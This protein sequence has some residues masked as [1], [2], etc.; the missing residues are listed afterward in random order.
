[1]P[2]KRKRAG[3]D[4]ETVELELTDPHGNRYKGRLTG[5]VIDGDDYRTIYLTEDERVV[6][7]DADKATYWVVEDPER[8]LDGWP[9]AL[10]ALGITPVVDI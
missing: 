9:A 4:A 6:V 3:A 10:Q 2:E 1:M 7:Y 8:E 5:T